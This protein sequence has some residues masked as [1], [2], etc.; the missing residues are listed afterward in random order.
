MNKLSVREEDGAKIIKELTGRDAIILV[1]PTM[2]LTKEKWLSISKEAENKPKGKYLLTYFLGNISNENK[3]IIK[4][5][6]SKNDLSIVNLANIKDYKTYLADP[7]EFI[8]YINSASILLTDSYHGTIFAILLEVPFIVFNREGSLHS[9]NSRIDTLLSKFKLESR[10]ADNLFYD[11]N[12]LLDSNKLFEVDYSHV[13]LILDAER[14]KAYDY[15]KEVL[16]L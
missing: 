12:N 10:R 15:L 8:D 2:M 9:M 16:N 4:L 14:K 1:D 3:K 5:I 7:S 13:P 6:A 11:K